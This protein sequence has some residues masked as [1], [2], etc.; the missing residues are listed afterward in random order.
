MKLLVFIIINTFSEG[1]FIRGLCTLNLQQYGTMWKKASCF[2]LFKSPSLN[3]FKI[4]CPQVI[5]RFVVQGNFPVIYERFVQYSS[6]VVTSASQH[7]YITI[8]Y[9]KIPTCCLKSATYDPQV[10]SIHL[11]S[12]TGNLLTTHSTSYHICMKGK[13]C[14]SLTRLLHNS[15]IGCLRCT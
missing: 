14:V 12:C 15:I 5:M 6:D 10:K 2:A 8:Y 7:R 1:S 9:C 13:Q 4:M 3:Q 11:D